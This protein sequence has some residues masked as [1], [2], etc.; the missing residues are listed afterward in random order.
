MATAMGRRKRAG[1]IK[2][3]EGSS[4]P[5]RLCH[6]CGFQPLETFHASSLKRG[7]YRCKTCANQTRWNYYRTE[8]GQCTIAAK[9]IRKREH[10]DFSSE[11]F[12]GALSRWDNRCFV[13]EKLSECGGF[14]VKKDI[15]TLITADPALPFSIHNSA[16]CMRSLARSL[17]WKLPSTMLPAWRARVAELGTAGGR[18]DPPS[19]DGSAATSLVLDPADD[20]VVHDTVVTDSVDS[21]SAMQTDGVAKPAANVEEVEMDKEA[22]APAVSMIED[23]TG[24][25]LGVRASAGLVPKGYARVLNR[26]KI[27]RIELGRKLFADLRKHNMGACAISV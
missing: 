11:D 9:E 13:S 19:P 22:S 15:L 3:V 10:V 6:S 18:R 7:I 23:V 2:I 24:K 4:S 27:E 16:L 17:G 20:G 12:A 8:K 14:A 1:L 26:E 5:L 21:G 25:A